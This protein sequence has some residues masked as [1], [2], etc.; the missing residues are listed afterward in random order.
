WE[1]LVE[2]FVQKFYH[3]FDHI[4]EE[5]D[6]EECDPHTFDDVPEIF[7][8]ED[9][10]FLFNTPLCIAFEE[11]NYLLKIDPEL[12]TYDIQGFKTYDEYEQE[13][14]NDKRKNLEEPWSENGIPYRLCDHIC[15]PYHFKNKKTKWPTSSSDIDGLCNG[16]EL[17]KMVRVGTMTYFQD[18][19]WYDELTDGKLNEETLALKAKVEGTWGDA[20]PGKMNAHEVAPFTRTVDFGRGPYANV[21]TERTHDSY[22]DT[23]RIFSITNGAS[24]VDDT[25]EDQGHEE[26][27]DDP[28]PE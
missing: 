11:F 7:K 26:V 18:H 14:N 4:E 15:K 24:N 28:T 22:L 1:N 16:G 5:E 8:I 21:K 25:Q 12:F 17:L 9:D 23:N 20:T 2:K 10:L 19:K 27:K 3:L 6:D 13:L